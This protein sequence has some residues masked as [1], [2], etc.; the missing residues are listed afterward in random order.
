MTTLDNITD[1]QIEALRQE[2]LA[3]GDMRMAAICRAALG[4]E[5]AAKDV[6]VEAIQEAEAMDDSD[7]FE[8]VGTRWDPAQC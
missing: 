3:A 5:H 2:A 7:S 6:C 1:A 8:E 4:G